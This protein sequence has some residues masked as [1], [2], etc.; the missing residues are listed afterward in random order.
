MSLYSFFIVQNIID[1]FYISVKID[2]SD[3]HENARRQK[4]KL[5][6]NARRQKYKLPEKRLK[7]VK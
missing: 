2:Y 7:R 1:P 6:E 3:I 5:P 4:Y